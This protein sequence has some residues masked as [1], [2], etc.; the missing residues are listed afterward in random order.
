MKNVQSFYILVFLIQI[1]FQF[2]SFLAHKEILKRNIVANLTKIWQVITQ[3]WFDIMTRMH[4][5][6]PLLLKFWN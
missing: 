1:E 3:W 5:N 2:N 6:M 4:V